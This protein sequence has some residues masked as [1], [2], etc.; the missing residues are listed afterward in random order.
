MAIGL[1]ISTE[2]HHMILLHIANISL[3]ILTEMLRSGQ[4]YESVILS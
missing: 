1:Y 2:I 3:Q 4:S